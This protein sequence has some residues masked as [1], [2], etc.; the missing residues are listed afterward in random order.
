MTFRSQVDTFVNGKPIAGRVHSAISMFVFL[1]G[2]KWSTLPVAG[3]MYD[4]HPDFV[5]KMMYIQSEVY[6]HERAEAIEREKR[7]NAKKPRVRNA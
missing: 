6:K 4:Q 1:Q 2:I 5:K 3:G 7:T